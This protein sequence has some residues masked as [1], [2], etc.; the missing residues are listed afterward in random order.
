[1]IYRVGK[2]NLPSFT[3]IFVA[4]VLL[5]LNV[6]SKKLF[7]ISPK[8]SWLNIN[9]LQIMVQ[10]HNHNL[11]NAINFHCPWGLYFTVINIFIWWIISLHISILLYNWIIHLLKPD[12]LIINIRNCYKNKQHPNNYDHSMPAL[13]C[14]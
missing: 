14:I 1:M 10:T 4:I 2:K 6:T 5:S 12:L 11:L 3:I 13:I 9:S 7:F 8:L